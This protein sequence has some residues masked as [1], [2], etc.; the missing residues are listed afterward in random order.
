M[1]DL[2]IGSGP[3]QIIRAMHAVMAEVA[4][5]AKDRK[6]THHNFNYTGH[7][8]V[9]WA[10]RP[11]FVRNGIVQ[12]ESTVG[13]ERLSV[14]STTKR[15][16]ETDSIVKVH[17]IVTWVSVE[18]GSQVQAHSY[19][20]SSMKGTT[21]DLQVGKAVSY[22]VKVAQLKTF[23]L[24]G[25]YEDSEKNAGSEQQDGNGGEPREQSKP[26]KESTSDEAVR[27]LIDRYGA[28]KEEKEIGDIRRA[29]DKIVR[30]TTEEQYNLLLAADEAASKR[31]ASS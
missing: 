1:E 20:E 9:T 15:G 31:I 2:P 26:A 3:R 16:E 4:G 28:A 17:V 5:V 19:G 12:L 22:A 30:S 27:L 18:D 24:L 23:M 6:N 10:L 13:H 25:G 21:A 7:D 11:A 8:D 14:T 29:V